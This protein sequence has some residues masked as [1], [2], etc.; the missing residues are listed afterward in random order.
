MTRGQDTRQ[1]APWGESG[2]NRLV[3]NRSDMTYGAE[4]EK[5]HIDYVARMKVSRC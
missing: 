3:R 2:E 1:Q 4:D 5:R